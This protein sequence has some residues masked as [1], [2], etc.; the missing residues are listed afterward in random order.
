MMVDN[1]K[2]GGDY[3]IGCGK[4]PKEHQFKPGQS[5]N[6]KGRP[7]KRKQKRIDAAAVLN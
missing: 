3:E 5:G 7:P 2:P 6:L 4:P 1:N